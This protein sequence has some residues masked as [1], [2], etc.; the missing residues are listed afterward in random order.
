M[1][2]NGRNAQEDA[3]PKTFQVAKDE[4]GNEYPLWLDTDQAKFMKPCQGFTPLG[5]WYYVVSGREDNGIWVNSIVTDNHVIEGFM[6]KESKSYTFEFEP[7]PV[8]SRWDNKSIKA[9]VRG[10]SPHLS[11]KDV[12][13]EIRAL[14]DEHCEFTDPEISAI[15]SLFTMFTYVHRAVYAMPILYITGDSG[16]GKSRTSDILNHLCYNANKGDYSVASLRRDIAAYAPTIILDD[17]E[18]LDPKIASEKSQYTQFI[19]RRIYKRGNIDKLR[20]K[21]DPK[22]QET[23]EIFCP[24]IISCI[25]YLEGALDTRTIEIRMIKSDD[26]PKVN[27]DLPREDKPIW[28]MLR[29]KLYVFGLDY[30]RNYR[31]IYDTIESPDFMRGRNFEIWRPILALATLVGEDVVEE[32]LR[33]SKDFIEDRYMERIPLVRRAILLALSEKANSMRKTIDGW[34]GFVDIPLSQLGHL[35]EEQMEALGVSPQYKMTPKRVGWALREIGL[36]RGKGIT[37]KFGRNYIEITPK[38]IELLCAK[39]IKSSEEEDAERTKT[40]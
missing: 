7:L 8:Q 9:Y 27:K 22:K 19:L 38:D 20:D 35:A 2:K 10:T 30:A 21:D 25:T 13:N 37:Y 17:A 15:L 5:N 3:P 36:R 32:I 40:A 4:G 28:Q 11:P 29:N 31:D 34:N 12:F 16:S 6:D 14:Y 39:Y 1:A 33:I 24:C 18:F 23:F 26:T